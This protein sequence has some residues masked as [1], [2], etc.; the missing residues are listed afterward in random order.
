MGDSLVVLLSP[1]RLLLLK[2]LVLPTW[3]KR[4]PR[5]VIRLRMSSR[6][7]ERR[8]GDDRHGGLE[9]KHDVHPDLGTL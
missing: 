2:L 7:R 6:Q 3:L 9:L 4:A 8:D 1:A 5:T